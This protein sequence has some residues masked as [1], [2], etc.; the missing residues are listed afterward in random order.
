MND[1][2]FKKIKKLVPFCEKCQSE[3]L[4]KDSMRFP[5]YCKC[6]EYEYDY[7]KMDY[8]LRKKHVK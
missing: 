4:E 2:N 6:G 8:V 3:I 5:Y 1:M 7:K